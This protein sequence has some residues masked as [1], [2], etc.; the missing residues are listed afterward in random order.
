MPEKYLSKMNLFSGAG[1]S[2]RV[3]LMWN[4]DTWNHQIFTVLIA[5]KA[6]VTFVKRSSLALIIKEALWSN[7]HYF[8]S[9]TAVRKNRVF[10]QISPLC[11]AY[12]GLWSFTHPSAWIKEYILE[13][14]KSTIQEWSFLFFFFFFFLKFQEPFHQRMWKKF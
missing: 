5:V 10:T 7:V 14:V 13:I 6:S 3:Y 12:E 8:H 2:N 9:L 1:I 4:V 11:M